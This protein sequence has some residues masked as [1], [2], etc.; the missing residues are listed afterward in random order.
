MTKSRKEKS[1]WCPT[2]CFGLIDIWGRIRIDMRWTE[3]QCIKNL[4]KSE[5]ISRFRIE[6]L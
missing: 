6:E 2:E 4:R 5:R 1:F 3:D